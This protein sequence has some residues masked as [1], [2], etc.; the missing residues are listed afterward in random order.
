MCVCVYGLVCE[1]YGNNIQVVSL[2][3]IS[4]NWGYQS[5]TPYERINIVL[6]FA[7]FVRPDTNPILGQVAEVIPLKTSIC[8]GM[9]VDFVNDDGCAANMDAKGFLQAV[10][11]PF[12]WLLLCWCR[13]EDAAPK[14]K[15][16]LTATVV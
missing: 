11:V 14:Q 5:L 13:D 9:A 12:L 10:T 6:S 2:L 15:T 3:R 1:I 8:C 4:T 16:P 7:F